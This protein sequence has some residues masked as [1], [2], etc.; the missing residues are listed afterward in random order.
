MDFKSLAPLKQ[1][2]LRQA[3]TLSSALNFSSWNPIPAKYRAAAAPRRVTR[4]RTSFPRSDDLTR[5]KTS[6]SPAEG[7]RELKARRWSVLDL[8]YVA[9]AAVFLFSLALS[10]AAPLLKT[11]AVMGAALLALMPVTRQV[12]WPGMTIWGY[13]VYFF[14]SRYVFSSPPL[15]PKKK[16]K[17]KDGIGN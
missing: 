8:Q 12:F 17:T 1:M 15:K 9:L 16:E 7:V 14:S 6:F 10:P 2:L 5:L 3:L 4:L 13:L 11:L